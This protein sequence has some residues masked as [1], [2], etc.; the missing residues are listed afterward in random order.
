M[1]ILIDTNIILD[2]VLSRK[3]F[4]EDS[5][6]VLK[7]CGEAT[8]TIGCISA[9]TITDMFYILRKDY[10]RKGQ[11]E[12][13]DQLSKFL[14]IVPVNYLNL[15]KALHNTSFTDIEDCLQA[16]CAREFGADYIVTRNV[17]DFTGSSIPAITPGEFIQL[18]EGTQQ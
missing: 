5:D 12:L 8:S 3:P 10:D 17:K 13:F 14:Y 15:Y 18:A 9:H 6:K 7:M 2:S 1:R 11:E 16:E 4:C